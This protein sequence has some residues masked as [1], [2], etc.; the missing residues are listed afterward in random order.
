[1]RLA[2]HRHA[3][4]MG[5]VPSEDAREI[6]VLPGGAGAGKR[7][8]V[9][10]VSTTFTYVDCVTGA[11][12]ANQGRLAYPLSDEQYAAGNVLGR[13]PEQVIYR[14]KARK[15]KS[16]KVP[17]VDRLVQPCPHRG[18]PR[19][20]CWVCP[21]LE[22]VLRVPRAGCSKRDEVRWENSP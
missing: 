18:N 10:D 15:K 20:G 21:A 11:L 7:N 19:R 17:K 4:G 22:E 16:E 1:M 5:N 8:G 14:V 12:H 3:G 2:G 6:L 9:W 13:F